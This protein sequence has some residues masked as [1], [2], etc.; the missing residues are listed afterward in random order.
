MSR[1]NPCSKCGETPTRGEEG[2]D[3]PGRL[4]HFVRCPR[5]GNQLV[6][7]GT[8]SMSISRFY[9]RNYVVELWNFRNPL[10]ETEGMG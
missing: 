7:D 3:G 10:P 4:M 8:D 5:C 2:F 1:A 6:N 9:Q